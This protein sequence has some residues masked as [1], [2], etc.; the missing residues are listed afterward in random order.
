MTRGS[1]MAGQAAHNRRVGVQF[2][3]ALPQPTRP[4]SPV[5]LDQAGGLGLESSVGSCRKLAV[6]GCQPLSYA[7]LS[8]VIRRCLV[9]LSLATCTA[10]ASRLGTPAGPAALSDPSA[11]A[12]PPSARYAAKA[13]GGRGVLALLQGFVVV[14]RGRSTSSAGPCLEVAN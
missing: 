14:A 10:V 6:N 4:A 11:A 5:L 12:S 3:P 2:P 1:L 9:R 13:G 8:R 7:L